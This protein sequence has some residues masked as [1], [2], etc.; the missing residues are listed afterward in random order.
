MIP[1]RL[2][3]GLI[4]SLLP[5]LNPARVVFLYD[6]FAVSQK[7]RN[8]SYRY[9]LSQEFRG[10]RMPKAVRM[11]LSF[12]T[13]GSFRNSWRILSGDG[14]QARADSCTV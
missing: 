9:S 12:T 14:L 5:A 8:N 7:V 6:L 4:Q 3:D 11:S 10:K 2:L 13:P 1:V